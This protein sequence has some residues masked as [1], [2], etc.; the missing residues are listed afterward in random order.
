MLL[1]AYDGSENADAA[2][3]AAAKLASGQEAVVLTTWEP[4]ID[5]MARNAAAGFSAAPAPYAS[6]I[7][8]EA[9]QHA[10]KVATAGAERA[11]AA[12]L[13]AEPRCEASIGGPA[14]TILEAADQLGADAIVIGTRGHGRMK[15]LL[16]GSVS[17][18]VVQHATRPVLVVPPGPQHED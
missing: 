6:E 17:H 16:L 14:Q 8:N 15:S 5:L 13:A 4:Y 12:G 7:D 11:T 18:S 2:I 1:I 9:K 10:L 3:D